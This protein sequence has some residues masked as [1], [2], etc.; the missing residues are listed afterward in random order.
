VSELLIKD[1]L[2]VLRRHGVTVL[3]AMPA[4]LT[5]SDELVIV[6]FLEASCGQHEEARDCLRGVTGVRRVEFAAHS[7]AVLHVLVDTK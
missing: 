6:I 1:L 3:H 2:V 4:T 5:P 7:R